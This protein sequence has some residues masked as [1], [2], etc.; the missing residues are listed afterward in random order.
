[1]LLLASNRT[2]ALIGG[3]KYC[4]V[5]EGIEPSPAPLSCTEKCRKEVNPKRLSLLGT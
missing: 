2:Q 4:I 3:P 1:M 5:K